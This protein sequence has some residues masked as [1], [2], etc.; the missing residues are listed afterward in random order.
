M[1]E[2]IL[3][4][5]QKLK[6]GNHMLQSENCLSL[7]T[8]H[9]FVFRKNYNIE[10]MPPFGH[11]FSLP[12]SLALSFRFCVKISHYQGAIAPLIRV[13]AEISINYRVD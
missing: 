11:T 13:A 7:L 6:F 3:K 2:T 10:L 12:L 9:C 5:C 8:V 1:S 4:N